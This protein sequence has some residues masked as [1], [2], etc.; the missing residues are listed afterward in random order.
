MNVPRV[1]Q[2]PALLLVFWFAG[3]KRAAA[4]LAN[5]PATAATDRTTPSTALTEVGRASTQPA[6]DRRSKLPVA[7][8]RHRLV[9]G[10]WVRYTSRLPSLPE[11]YYFRFAEDGTYTWVLQTDLRTPSNTGHW[12]LS[13][14]ADGSDHLRLTD[15]QGKTVDYWLSFVRVD[16]EVGML[17]VSGAHYAGEQ[18]LRHEGGE[19]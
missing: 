13:R 2:I 15:Q 8:V 17:L 16:N 1:V 18:P 4:P 3:C 6:E 19:D 11:R 10:W 9:S 7:E 12:K 5:G 14:E